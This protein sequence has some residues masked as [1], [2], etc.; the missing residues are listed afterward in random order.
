[1]PRAPVK[2]LLQKLDSGVVY[3]MRLMLAVIGVKECIIRHVQ[4][5]K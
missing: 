1:M 3:A 2:K 5:P 4:L